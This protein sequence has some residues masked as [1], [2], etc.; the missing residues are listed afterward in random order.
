LGQRFSDFFIHR[1]LPKKCLKCGVK[2]SVF[3]VQGS[4]GMVL[5]PSLISRSFVFPEH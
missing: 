2:C 5:V 4:G 1:N 3:S